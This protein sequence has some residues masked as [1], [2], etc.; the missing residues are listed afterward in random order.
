MSGSV[1]ISGVSAPDVRAFGNHH[2]SAVG[3][4]KSAVQIVFAVNSQ[5]RAFVYAHKF[6]HDGIH[7][8]GVP[9]DVYMIKNNGVAH[10][11]P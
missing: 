4:G 5:L 2:N 1:R 9:A 11:R 7:Y 3:N 8:G 10:R 6:I